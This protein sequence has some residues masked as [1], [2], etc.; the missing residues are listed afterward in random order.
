MRGIAFADV[1]ECLAVITSVDHAF[2]DVARE[3]LPLES[4]TAAKFWLACLKV[5][6]SSE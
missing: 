4:G 3:G 2:L 6:R 5:L 1:D